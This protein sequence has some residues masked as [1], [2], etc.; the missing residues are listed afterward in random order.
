MAASNEEGAVG[1]PEV[2]GGEAG[3]GGVVDGRLLQVVEVGGVVDVAERVQLVVA[4]A[5]VG[6]VVVLRGGVTG[7]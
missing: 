2:V 4:D 7:S 5:D 1:G 3:D 6:K